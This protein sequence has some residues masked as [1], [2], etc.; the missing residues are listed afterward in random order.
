MGFR[1]V[2]WGES[3]NPNITCHA[4]RW[5]SFR[6]PNLRGLAKIAVGALF[7]GIF[8]GVALVSVWLVAITIILASLTAWYAWYT[9]AKPN[10][11]EYA[12]SYLLVNLAPWL[13]SFGTTYGPLWML[14][15]ASLQ[16]FR[17]PYYQK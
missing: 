13:P 12:L 14:I 7:Y 4:D 3:A 11:D 9:D 16:A 8:S 6:H 10:S 17:P 2:G 5:G 15:Q 1:A